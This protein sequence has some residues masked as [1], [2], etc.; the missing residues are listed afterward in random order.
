MNPPPAPSQI[1]R[2]KNMNRNFEQLRWSSI[3]KT[4]KQSWITFLLDWTLLLNTG[5]TLTFI[6]RWWK[7]TPLARQVATGRDAGHSSSLC[8][9]NDRGVRSPARSKWEGQTLRASRVPPRFAS[10]V[11]VS[12]SWRSEWCRHGAVRKAPGGD[13]GNEPPERELA[14][15]TEGEIIESS[16]NIKV[17]EISD[18]LNWK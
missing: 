12:K 16:K 10:E 13:G 6:I 7:H 14:K 3:N 15:G 11:S 4:R 5:E 9:R 8:S 17:T 1:Q 2:T 18:Q